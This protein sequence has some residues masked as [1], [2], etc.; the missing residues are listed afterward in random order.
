MSTNPKSQS[1]KA[2]YP[3]GVKLQLKPRRILYGVTIV[4]SLV[5]AAICSLLATFAVPWLDSVACAAK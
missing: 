5:P 3:F 4:S 1:G 2:R